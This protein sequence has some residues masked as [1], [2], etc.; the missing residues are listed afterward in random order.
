LEG[1]LKR[2]FAI[3]NDAILEYV[4][5]QQQELARTIESSGRTIEAQAHETPHFDAANPQQQGWRRQESFASN[6]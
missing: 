5:Q 6:R 4:Q 1:E 3:S 2:R